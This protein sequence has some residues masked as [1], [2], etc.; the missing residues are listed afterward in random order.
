MANAVLATLQTEGE[1]TIAVQLQDAAGAITA[2]NS[3]RITLVNGDVITLAVERSEPDNTQT[4]IDPNEPI[5]IYFNKA[6]DPTLVLNPDMQ[7][8]LWGTIEVWANLNKG[9]LN[10]VGKQ[11][12]HPVMLAQ[13]GMTTQAL[14]NRTAVE[15][16]LGKNRCT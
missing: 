15:K 10:G 16:C 13:S 7:N 3:S 5:N 14:L 9:R 2:Q 4:K 12:L 6:I 8:P 11:L 1:H